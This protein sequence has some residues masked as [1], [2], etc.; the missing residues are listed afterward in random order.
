MQES[1]KT[2]DYSLATWLCYRKITLLGTVELP[3][4]TRK[5]FVFLKTPDIEEYI[6]E[7]NASDDDEVLTCKRFFR[8]H[9]TVKHALKD[10]YSV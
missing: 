9:T 2:A 3:N 7:W 5:R 10:S 4:D 6:E 8:A 1:F